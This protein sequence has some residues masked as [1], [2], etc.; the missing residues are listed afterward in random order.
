MPVKYQ[1]Y[2]DMAGKFRFRLRAENNKIV[3]VSEAYERKVGAM[4]GVKSVQANCQSEIEDTTIRAEK[5][6]NPKYTI[7]TDVVSKFRFNL[8][9]SNGEIIATSE[10]YETKQGCMIGIQAVQNS[11][12]AKIEDLTIKQK[13]EKSEVV[14]DEGIVT[15]KLVFNPPISA[16][17]GS[18]IILQ[19]KLMRADSEEGISDVKIQIMDADRS[20]MMDDIITFATTKTDGT[21]SVEW[22]AKPMD[23]I[24]NTVEIYAVFKGKAAFKPTCSKKKV[25]SVIRG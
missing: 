11:C 15:T 25:L 18:T 12:S 3:A 20:F 4:N 6:T 8:S 22:I 2:K 7:F 24:D 19:G 1:V 10:G 21:F 17:E 23:W 9:A 16:K 14:E 13:V 5:L